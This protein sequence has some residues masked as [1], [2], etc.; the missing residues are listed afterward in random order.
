MTGQ[1]AE[2]LWTMYTLLL[3]AWQ[4]RGALGTFSCEIIKCT[5]VIETVNAFCRMLNLSTLAEANKSAVY[6]VRLW[7]QVPEY[8]Y[9]LLS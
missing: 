9:E 8:K 4:V 7:A 6:A 5:S 2:V 1:C 3:F